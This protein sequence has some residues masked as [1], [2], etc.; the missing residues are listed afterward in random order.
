MNKEKKNTFTFV[1]SDESVNKYGYRV[2]TEGIDLSEF[3]KNPVMLFNHHRSDDY[4]GKTDLLPVGRWDNIRK[5]DK[6]RLLMD[7]VI[8]TSDDLGKKMISKIQQGMLNAASIGI[9][10][11]ELSND[12]DLILA[13]QTRPT[14]K[15]SVL[16]EV[17]IVDIPANKNA[18][19]LN[20]AGTFLNLSLSEDMEKLNKELP[21]IEKLGANLSEAVNTALSTYAEA[22]GITTEEAVITGAE[23]LDIDLSGILDSS[24]NCP[25][26][27]TLTSLSEWLGVEV[28]AL[29]EAGRLDGCEYPEEEEEQAEEIQQNE[30]ELRNTSF[31]ALSAFMSSLKASYKLVR[32]EETPEGKLSKLFKQLKADLTAFNTGKDTEHSEELEEL[33]SSLEILKAELDLMKEH[34]SGNEQT[35]QKLKRANLKL[36]GKATIKAPAKEEAPIT[37]NKEEFKEKTRLE[38]QYEAFDTLGKKHFKK[39]NS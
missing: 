36:I 29:V 3:E 26:I 20:F 16:Q 1:V 6:N 23:A 32:K 18:M 27:E 30:E 10:V 12:P 34:V 22:N 2:L 33:S 5:D 39:K 8:D 19:R 17:S 14:I 11:I 35:I 25:T 24:D 7:A 15:R 13:D 37:E 4:T 38:R 31:S 9:G 28:S 21:K